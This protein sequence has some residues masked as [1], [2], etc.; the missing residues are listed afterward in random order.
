MT[1]LSLFLHNRLSFDRF[2]GDSYDWRRSRSNAS[3]DRNGRPELY[4]VRTVTTYGDYFF[5]I[6]SFYTTGQVS[7][8][9]FR[10]LT[11]KT[12][13]CFAYTFEDS[14]V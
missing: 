14:H 7:S 11:A 12:P 6:R 8:V 9:L 5:S 1:P 2:Y 4:L 10:K 13:S 3:V